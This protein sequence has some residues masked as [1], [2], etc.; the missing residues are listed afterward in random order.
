MCFTSGTASTCGRCSAAI[1]GVPADSDRGWSEGDGGRRPERRSAVVALFSDLL[2][3]C[4]FVEGWKEDCVEGRRRWD[5]S[6]TFS[7]CC[8]VWFFKQ[9]NLLCAAVFSWLYQSPGLDLCSLTVHSN[10]VL[11]ALSQTDVKSSWR[12]KVL[13]SYWLFFSRKKIFYLSKQ[14]SEGV[15]C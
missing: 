14:K 3:Q 1:T 9:E 5:L 10:P 15:G 6:Q 2:S 12:E 7:L 4:V 13:S 8:F 11:S